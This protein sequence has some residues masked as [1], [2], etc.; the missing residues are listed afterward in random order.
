VLQVGARP[1]P[2]TLDGSHRR[3]ER[4][5]SFSHGQATKETA[6]DDSRHAFVALPEL[7]ERFV[8]R[9]QIGRFAFDRGS[10]FVKRHLKTGAT[11]FRRSPAPRV[12]DQDMAHRSGSKSEKLGARPP[13]TVL[14]LRQLDVGLMY[15]RRRIDGVLFAV[16]PQ[17]PMRDLPQV[18]VDQL[19]Q[20]AEG[21][22]VTVAPALDQPRDVAGRVGIVR[23]VD[24]TP[25][26][27]PAVRIGSRT[28]GPRLLGT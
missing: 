21:T 6:F 10:V 24:R 14:V 26:S 28:A 19:D 20:T 7:V 16:Q 4:L 23:L 3:I 15:E 9:E 25:S 11:P 1:C 13:H 17:V 22:V 8:E 5:R 12:I 18:T 2:V 27:G